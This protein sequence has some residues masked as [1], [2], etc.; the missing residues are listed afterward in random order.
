[1]LSSLCHQ[2]CHRLQALLS[3]GPSTIQLAPVWILETDSLH[4]QDNFPCLTKS[5][6]RAR[7]G[8][9]EPFVSHAVIDLQWAAGGGGA[10]HGALNVSSSLVSFHF[11]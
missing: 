2:D 1:M 7:S 5:F 10:S 9:P 8:D 3:S 11:L 6:A 4:F